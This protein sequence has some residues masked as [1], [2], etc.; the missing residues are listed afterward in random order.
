MREGGLDRG[1]SKNE[2]GVR[3]NKGQVESAMALL[4]DGLIEK[5]TI[6]GHY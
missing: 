4:S 5:P 6:D 1:N 2:S 3:R